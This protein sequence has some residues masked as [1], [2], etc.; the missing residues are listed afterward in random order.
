MCAC[1]FVVITFMVL[2]VILSQQ[3]RELSFDYYYY[4]LTA[5]FPGQS[6]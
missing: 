5:S 6:G 2:F 3:Y 1:V 4:H